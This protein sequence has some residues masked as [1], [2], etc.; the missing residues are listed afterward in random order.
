MNA[1]EREAVLSSSTC[2]RACVHHSLPATV[3]RCV[4]LQLALIR[5]HL[6]A[7]DSEVPVSPP[8]NLTFSKS[9]AAVISVLLFSEITLE[10]RKKTLSVKLCSQRKYP[11]LLL[12]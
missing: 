6:G 9:Q 3:H 2:V 7:F 8:S 10:L 12:P 1:F 4:S 5:S 11:S